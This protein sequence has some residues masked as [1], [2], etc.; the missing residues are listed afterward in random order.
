MTEIAIIPNCPTC[1]SS[2]AVESKV[3]LIGKAS[4]NILFDGDVPEGYCRK[5]QLAVDECLR[6]AVGQPPLSQFVNGFFCRQCGR[7]FLPEDVRRAS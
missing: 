7:A 1:V 4:P 3:L 6:S 2:Q 5:D